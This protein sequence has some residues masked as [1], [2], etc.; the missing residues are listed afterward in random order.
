M[1]T[2]SYHVRHTVLVQVS[3]QGNIGVAHDPI[4]I[5]TTTTTV[6]VQPETMFDPRAASNQPP[7][8]FCP[9]TAQEFAPGVWLGPYASLHN[10][11]LAANNV[12]IIINC[13]STTSLLSYLNSCSILSD[14]IIVSLDPSYRDG[15]PLVHQ[16]VRSFNKVL[17]NYLTSFYRR[18]T[19]VI[20]ELPAA[21]SLLNISSPILTGNLKLQ[22]FN[23]VRLIKLMSSINPL[24]Q[25]LIV[26]ETGNTSLS[27]A[28]AIAYL[29]DTYNYNVAASLNVLRT[30]RPSVHDLNYNFYDDLLIVENLK[31][32]HAENNTIKMRNPGVLTTNCKLKRRSGDDDDIELDLDDGITVGDKR[33]RA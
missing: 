15:S 5:S 26:S 19:N 27:T 25:T 6:S 8:G 12:K 30:K 22:F 23:L 20:H 24:I 2:A 7:F 28:L 4:S 29:M 13:G 14:I 1:K 33:R 9:D 31:K 10:Q 3:E 16:F 11:F 18:D 17:Q 21:L 32:F